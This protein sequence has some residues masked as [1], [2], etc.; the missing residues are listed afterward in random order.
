MKVSILIPHWRSGRMTTFAVS[1]FLKYAGRDAEV[2]VVNNSP[3]DNSIN[4][5]SPIK[6]NWRVVDN[7]SD[8]T[9]SHGTAFD[10]AIPLTDSEWI[11][12]AESDSFPTGPFLDSYMDIVLNGYDAAGSV[13]SLSGGTFMHPTGSIYSRRV[14][15]D[16]K[17][18]CDNIPYTYFPGMAMKDGLAAHLM[19]HESL[20][21]EFLAEP[22]DYIELTD[23]YR[24]YS[25]EMAIKKAEHYRPVVGPFH[26]GCGKNNET[27]WSYGA[28]TIESEAKNILLDNR[29]KIV[30]RFGMEPG[31]WLS[32]YMSAAGYK[33]CNIPI[34]TKWMPG[35]ENEQQEYTLSATGIKHLWAGSSFL[36]MKDT[37]MHDVYEFKKNQIEE[38]YNSL[39]EYLKI[40][41]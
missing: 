24:P 30:T 19:V 14:W 25:A 1:Q 16:A 38:L 34:K 12:T 37:A 29:L 26:N 27:K 41:E 35:R 40:K 6:G 18:Y 11:F 36:S 31:Q 4:C 8:K 9:S 3:G 17:R 7:L 20:L 5:L 33:V 32:Y 15:E 21:N 28:R 23:S 2:V 13:L 10:L 22:E 39:P